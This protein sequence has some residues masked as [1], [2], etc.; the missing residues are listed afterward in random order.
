MQFI[1]LK[2]QQEII[3]KQLDENIANVLSHGRFVKGPEID[4]IEEELCGFTGAKHAIAC[5]SGTDALQIALMA[6][7]LKPGDEIITSPFT[8]FA[9]AEV[10]ELLGFRPVFVDIES[11]TYNIDATKIEAKITNRTKAI[12]PVSLYG[13]CSD[14]DMINQ[15]ARK[16]SLIVLEDAAQSFGAT[17][18]ERMSCNL[19]HMAA[20]SFFPSKPL[21]CYGDGGMVFTSDE[22]WAEKLR[23]MANHG[24]NDRS[25]YV[26]IGINSRLDTLQAA[27]LLAKMSVFEEE[28]SKRKTIGVRY[29]ELLKKHVKTPVVRDDRTCVYAQYT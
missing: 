20:T 5:A 10:I 3:K 14:M 9:T 13:Q 15:M 21:G 12:I 17:Y 29:T 6:L 16:H 11:D 19:S 24:K 18:K 26:E 8:F 7:H 1:D 27:V 28:I 22:N 23:C 25:H 2:K 4:K